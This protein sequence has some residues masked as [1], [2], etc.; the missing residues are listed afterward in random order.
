MVWKMQLKQIKMYSSK[1]I[2]KYNIFLIV[3]IY[4]FFPKGL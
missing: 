1:E 4:F 3:Y 2:L